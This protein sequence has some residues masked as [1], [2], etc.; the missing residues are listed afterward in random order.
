MKLIEIKQILPAGDWYALYEQEINETPLADRIA[1]WAS[2]ITQD[3]SEIY[4]TVVGLIDA[5]G[6]LEPAEEARNFQ[7]YC[8]KDELETALRKKRER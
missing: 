5:G 7:G 4:P 8:H 3:G 1:V 6:F 2:V